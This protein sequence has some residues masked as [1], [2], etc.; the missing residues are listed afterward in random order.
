MIAPHP[1][2][3]VLIASGV[4]ARAVMRGERV[5]VLVMTNGDADCAHD[6]IARQRES[7]AGL[8]HVGVPESAV[9]FLGYPDGALSKLGRS[10]LSV[11]RLARDGACTSGAATYGDRGAGGAASGGAPYTREAVTSDL[12]HALEELAPTD[13]VVTHSADTHPDH[14]STYALF[15]D[16]LDRVPRAPRVHR[17]IV[18]NGDCWPLGPEPHEPCPPTRIAPTLPTPPLSN[19]LAGYE[20][21]ERIAVPPSFLSADREK[22]PKIAAIAEHRSQTRGTF[23][24]YLFAFARSDEAFFPE[25]YERRGA[26]WQRAGTVASAVA[27]ARV[28]R[29]STKLALPA[30]ATTGAYAL[31][32]DATRG[33]ATIVRTGG[34]GDTVLGAFPLPHDLWS[35]DREEELE[36]RADA[37]SE[38]GAVEISLRCR[39]ALVGVAVSVSPSARREP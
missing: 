28:S 9:R 8:A 19:R 37:R 26:S 2:D 24:S 35:S 36:L 15:R 13:V 31:D 16:A 1:D 18:H 22:N 7:I 5:A 39:S 30:N 4:L 38:D 12:A 23:E 32:I 33:E 10:A 11:R 29:T 21:R 14:A 17:A 34:D 25:T 6:G 20:P 3:E 27:R